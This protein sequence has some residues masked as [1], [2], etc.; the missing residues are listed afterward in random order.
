MLEREL[1]HWGYIVW[2]LLEQSVSFL[3]HSL[4]CCCVLSGAKNSHVGWMLLCSVWPDPVGYTWTS[5]DAK[6]SLKCSKQNPTASSFRLNI[7]KGKK[8]AAS[9]TA[10]QRYISSIWNHLTWMAEKGTFKQKV[11]PMQIHY[12]FV[13]TCLLLQL[14]LIFTKNLSG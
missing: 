10:G 7:P 11:H 4:Y 14:S 12:I 13:L 8:Q 6:P 2:I 3:G 5:T 9:I 1:A